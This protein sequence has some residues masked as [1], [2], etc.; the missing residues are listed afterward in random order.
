MPLIFHH[1][2]PLAVH[3]ECHS[4]FSNGLYFPGLVDIVHRGR[5]RPRV[6]PPPQN[7]VTTMHWS[8][9]L[10]HVLWGVT[11][12]RLVWVRPGDVH[13]SQDLCH[14]LSYIP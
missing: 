13:L 11:L 9:G 6:A 3:S 10:G 8:V 2:T 4:P 1:P 12:A 5:S 7:L 14:L